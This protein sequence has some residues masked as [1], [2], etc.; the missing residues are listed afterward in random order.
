NNKIL[1][2][3][4]PYLERDPESLEWDQY[5]LLGSAA[6]LGCVRL[7]VADSKW[8]YDNCKKGTKVVV[9][10]DKEDVGELGKPKVKKIDPNSKNRGWDPTDINPLNPW[11]MEKTA[12]LN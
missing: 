3:S 7:S 1:F 6:S 9:Y 5:N 10:D 4:V 11:L 8:I 2:H 12:K